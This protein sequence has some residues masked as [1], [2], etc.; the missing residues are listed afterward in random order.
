MNLERSIGAGPRRS[1][2]QACTVISNFVVEIAKEREYPD[3]AGIRAGFQT[4]SPTL[5]VML[6]TRSLGEPAISVQ[7]PELQVQFSVSYSPDAEDNLAVPSLLLLDKL[8]ES[9]PIQ[10]VLHSTGHVHASLQER[11]RAASVGRITFRLDADAPTVPASAPVPP[12]PVPTPGS[13]PT[14]PADSVTR[15]DLIPDPTVDP[16]PDLGIPPVDDPE[17]HPAPDLAQK[18]SADGFHEDAG[19]GDEPVISLNGSG[20]WD[21]EDQGYLGHPAI[22]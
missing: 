2:D 9:D 22:D 12:A 18:L 20:G 16:Y 19:A 6:T 13:A 5:G 17:D 10:V 11:L 4:I 15:A 7:M 21:D 1:A 14:P 3:L 8:A